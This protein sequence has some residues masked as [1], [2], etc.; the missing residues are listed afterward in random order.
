M[1]THYM[2][3]LLLLSQRAML[4]SSPS[5]RPSTTFVCRREITVLAVKAPLHVARLLMLSKLFVAHIGSGVV[6]HMMISKLFAAHISSG[7]LLQMRC[8]L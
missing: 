3:A 2:L 7:V 8:L 5:E 1:K 4:R 6:L